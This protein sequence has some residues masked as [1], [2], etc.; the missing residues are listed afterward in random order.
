MNEILSDNKADIIKQVNAKRLAYKDEWLFL[1]ILFKGEQVQ[2]KSYNT[3]LQVLR[4][5]GVNHSGGMD[6][7][8]KDFKASLLASL[9]LIEA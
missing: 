7:N 8:V 6:A 3:W 9:E 5:K 4:V 1:T 2:I